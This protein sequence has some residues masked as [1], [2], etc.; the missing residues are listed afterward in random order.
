MKLI[1]TLAVLGMISACHS[2]K[3]LSRS[4]AKRL[5]ND[6]FKTITGPAA[7]KPTNDEAKQLVSQG[8]ISLTHNVFCNCDI[9]TVL[10]KGKN[11]FRGWQGAPATGGFYLV[12][13][14]S[15]AGHVV[16]VTGISNPPEDESGNEKTVD[17]TWTYDWSSAPSEYSGLLKGSPPTTR[18]SRFRLYDDG[19][20]LEQF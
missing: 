7:F 16:D 1:W 4:S 15:F 11:F 8:A 6:Y 19:W 10:P 12:T 20:R 14:D 18:Q 3:D 17:Y 9:P 2:S 5:I 13:A